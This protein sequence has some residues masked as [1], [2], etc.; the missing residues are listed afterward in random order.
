MILISTRRFMFSYSD[1]NAS[2][3]SS[4][5]AEEYANDRRETGRE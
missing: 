3:G 2:A 5:A 1:L 4:I